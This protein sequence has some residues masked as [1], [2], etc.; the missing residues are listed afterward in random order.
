MTIDCR[1]SS[2]ESKMVK[3]AKGFVRE[4]EASR[5]LRIDSSE[6]NAQPT[7]IFENKLNADGL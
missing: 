3:E 7:V 2:G 5:L 6:A 1:V 4:T